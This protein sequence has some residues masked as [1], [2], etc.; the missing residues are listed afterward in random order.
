VLRSIRAFILDERVMN[1]W[2]RAL[3]VVQFIFNTTRHRD[4]GFTSADFFFGPAVNMNRFLL[5]ARG[6]RRTSDEAD[7]TKAVYWI[8][9]GSTGVW[10][11]P[12]VKSITQ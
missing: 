2:T 8:D 3:P 12:L 7:V 5:N 6:K 1:D 4:I 11:Y 10:W 9:S